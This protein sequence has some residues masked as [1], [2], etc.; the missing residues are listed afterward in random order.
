[1]HDLF[2]EHARDLRRYLLAHLP[3]SDVDDAL[4]EVFLVAVRR[5]DAIPEPALPWLVTVARNVAFRTRRG[6]WRG[7]LLA[8]R[9]RSAIAAPVDADHADAVVAGDAVRRAWSDL[10]EQ[11]REV[12]A[13]AT[14]DALSADQAAQ[15]LGCSRATYDVRLHRSRRRLRQAL[16]L[17][18]G[19]VSSP[20]PVTSRLLKEH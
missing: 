13:L 11:D 16:Q 12:L 15:C 17:A 3:L 19:D 4:G 20:T 5:V 6:R 7:D 18:D 1:M 14:V 8:L 9:L 10:R 2:V